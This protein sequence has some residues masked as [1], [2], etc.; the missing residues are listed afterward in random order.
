MSDSV[1][2]RLLAGHHMCAASRGRSPDADAVVSRRLDV[3]PALIAAI[4]SRQSQAG[5]S[6]RADGFGQFDPNCFGLMQV[7]SS[8][9]PRSGA[10]VRR[11]V[12][13]LLRLC[14]LSLSADQQVSPRRERQRVQRGPCGPGGHLPHPAHQD[15]EEDE[16]TVEQR[17]AAER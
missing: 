8:P 7:R 2:R 15:H 17:A 5:T 12:G 1:R 16:E 3:H 6:L 10:S 11:S 13:M 9:L 4:I 14:D